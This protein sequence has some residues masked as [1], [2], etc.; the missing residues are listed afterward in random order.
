MTQQYL[1]IGL[2]EQV[3]YLGDIIKYLQIKNVYNNTRLFPFKLYKV[4]KYIC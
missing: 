2:N 1:K 3:Y 4:C